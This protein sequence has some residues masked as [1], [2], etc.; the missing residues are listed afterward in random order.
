MIYVD[1]FFYRYLNIIYIK[2]QKYIDVDLSYGGISID[3]VDQ[4]LEI[5]EVSRLKKV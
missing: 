1:N 3:I 5:G 4:L 2:K